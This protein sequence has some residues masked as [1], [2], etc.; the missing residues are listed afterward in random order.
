MRY[1]GKHF[2]T[3]SS[4][5]FSLAQDRYEKEHEGSGGG[6]KGK[7]IV[8]TC[9][10]TG[11]GLLIRFCINA[12][13]RVSHESPNI[14]IHCEQ[15]PENQR[16]LRQFFCLFQIFLVFLT[17]CKYFKWSVHNSLIDLIAAR[18]LFEVFSLFETEQQH[19]FIFIYC[20]INCF[21]I[22][23]FPTKV[24]PLLDWIA[25]E[26][27]FWSVGSRTPRTK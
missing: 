21:L 14:N 26:N 20:T 11:K 16:F 17:I 22:M 7:D 18:F 2:K 13:S 12:P 25:P 19:A 5:T 15:P 24:I 9:H 27:P 6:E 1:F 3:P 23:F 10:S 4:Y 8:T